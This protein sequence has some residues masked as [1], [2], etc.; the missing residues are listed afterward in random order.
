[1]S[2]VRFVHVSVESADHRRRRRNGR[3]LAREQPREIDA[4]QQSGR[5]AFSVTFYA[6]N[7]PSEQDRRLVTNCQMRAQCRRRVEIGI[8]V[9]RA[10]AQELRLSKTW[11]HPENALLLGNP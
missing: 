8:A 2:R 3:H 9:N 6:G 7:L 10:V 4:R 1:M 11:N 5:R